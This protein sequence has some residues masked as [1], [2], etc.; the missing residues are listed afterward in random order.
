MLKDAE[1][2][3]GQS[4]GTQ[5]ETHCQA[6][7][8]IHCKIHRQTHREN[9]HQLTVRLTVRHREIHRQT[10]RKT[11]TSDSSHTEH[12][13]GQMMDCLQVCCQK[14]CP[15]ATVALSRCYAR[16]PSR[17]KRLLASS[18]PS[19]CLFVLV[20]RLGPT[21]RISVEL[22]TAD[23]G[24]KFVQKRQIWLQS[25][26]KTPVVVPEGLRRH[27]FD[28]NALL[29]NNQYF[30]TADSDMQLNNTHTHT[31]RRHCCVPTRTRRNLTIYVH[32]LT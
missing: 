10:H 24:K 20:Y 19:V 13:D 18:R 11:S 23:F 17:R 22:C 29:C 7:R 2:K 4:S 8:K 16:S 14:H 1:H 32:C 15:P 28:I 12:Q 3:E 21:A 31:H 25:D 5:R 9:R 27:T 6:H 30:C 26:T